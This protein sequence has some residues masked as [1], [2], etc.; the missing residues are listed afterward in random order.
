MISRLIDR[1]PH[2]TSVVEFGMGWGYWCRM[3]MAFNYRVTGIELSP[4]R[5]AHAASMGVASVPAIDHLPPASVHF[6]YANQVFEHLAEPQ[7]TMRELSALLAEDGVMLI[8]VPNARH[9]ASQLRSNG[10]QPELA[11]IHPLEHINAF[12]R[13]SLLRAARCARLRPASVPLRLGSRSLKHF[14]SSARREFNDRF[15][16][17]HIYLVKA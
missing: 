17:P 3:A 11:A 4:E 2:E 10:W 7:Q 13:S 5:V 1:A 9:T 15:R 8:R 16:E 14:W 12:T 6:I